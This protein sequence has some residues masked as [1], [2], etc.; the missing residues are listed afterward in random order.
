MTDNTTTVPAAEKQ[1][2]KAWLLSNSR[3]RWR[4]PAVNACT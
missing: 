4:M 3:G 1:G 2:L